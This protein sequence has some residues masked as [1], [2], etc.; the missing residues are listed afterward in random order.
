MGGS[1]GVSVGGSA[2]GSVANGCS[3]TSGS[4]GATCSIRDSL[5]AKLMKLDGRER[6]PGVVGVRLGLGDAE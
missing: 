1:T 5:R 2:V 6:V 4:A 3:K